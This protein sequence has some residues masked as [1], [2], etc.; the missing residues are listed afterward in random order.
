LW[1]NEWQEILELVVVKIDQTEKEIFKNWL[2]G[3][4]KR[5]KQECNRETFL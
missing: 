2:N 1:G 4:R 5:K 3:F